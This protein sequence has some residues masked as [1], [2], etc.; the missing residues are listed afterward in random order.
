MAPGTPGGDN[1]SC[2][3][4]GGDHIVAHCPKI[5][6]MASEPAKVR[7]IIRALQ[8]TI[9]SRGGAQNSSPAHFRDSGARTPPL[10]NQTTPIRQVAEATDA[11]DEFTD[12]DATIACLDTDDDMTDDE[13]PN[14]P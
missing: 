10:S 11:D 4:C 7:S 1:R 9:E 14:F 6:A 3:Y 12:D 2:H 5:L 8:R 13:A